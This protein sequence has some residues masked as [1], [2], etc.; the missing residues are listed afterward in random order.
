M[1]SSES[2]ND[3]LGAVIE[4]Y[5]SKPGSLLTVLQQAQKIFGWLS[6][7]TMRRVA[8][9][10]DLPAAQVESVASYYSF[11][12]LEPRGE[13]VIRVCASAPCHIGGADRV[14]AALEETLGI[15]IGETTKDMK[16]SLLRCDCLG[17]CDRA[18][19]VLIGEEVFG[20]LTA[21]EVPELISRYR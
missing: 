8:D 6:H 16:F 12:H 7:R 21:E 1:D 14:F 3:A 20:P 2:K 4:S 13:T 17:I 9:G 10:L 19:A 15:R 11:F 18:P 5:K